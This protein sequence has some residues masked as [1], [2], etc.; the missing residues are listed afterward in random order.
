MKVPQGYS[1]NI[2]SLVSMKDLK[3]VALKSHDCHVLM[4]Q[5]LPVAIRGILPKN[6]R[7]V[8][9]RLCIFFNSICQKVIEPNTLNDLENEAVIILCQLEMYFPPSFFDIM[10]HLIVHLVR[11]IKICGPVFLRWMYPVERYMKI[12]KGYVKNPYR[13]EASIIERY[14]AEEAIEFC[15]EYLSD[16]E[17]IG[18]PKSRHEGRNEGKGTRGVKVVRKDQHEVLQA[19]FYI[20][21]NTNDV[22]PYIDSHKSLLKSTN[23]RANEKWLLIEHNKTFMKWFKEKISQ[24]DCDVEHLKWLARGPNFDV[25]T[26]TGY[27]INMLS[28]Y[29]K[30]EDDKSTMQNSGVT[31]EAKSMHFSSS[32]D[33]N[34]IMASI[35]YYGVIEEIWEVDYIKFRVP[36]FKCKW[37]DINTRVHV[38][39]LG[40]TLVDLK[41]V[42][43]KED[44]FIMAYQ[45]KQVFYVNDP[46]NKRWSIVLQGKVKH[47]GHDHDEST[48]NLIDT[49]SLLRRIPPTN[50]EVDND[51][52]HATRN[53]HNEGIWENI[54]TLPQ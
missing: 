42:S 3:L 19:H 37:V 33:N 35:S 45:A 20:L 16:V 34:P 28:F 46:S 24:E 15:T 9:T 23:P 53:D 51:E 17:V 32:K 2:K 18:I 30:V 44:P 13:P 6:V 41:K 27:D 49:P 26:W 7:Q 5:L 40:F 11:E 43:Y 47:D 21:N 22:I 10:V 12:L 4:Q 31:L 1:S 29:T 25:I 48:L 38:D 52:V 8:I 14:I 36:V 39:E 50:D 54:L